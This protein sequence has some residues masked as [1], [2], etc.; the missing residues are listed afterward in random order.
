M[1]NALNLHSHTSY[2][3]SRCRDDLFSEAEAASSS[4][5]QMEA[6]RRERAA[7]EPVTKGSVAQKL[8]SGSAMMATPKDIGCTDC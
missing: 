7:K 8:G 4:F 5:E 3:A 1:P 2:D 6:D